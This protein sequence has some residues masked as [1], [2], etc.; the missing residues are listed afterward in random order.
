MIRNVDLAA[1]LQDV[2][3]RAD[4]A[5]SSDFSSC[6]PLHALLG[7]ALSVL[8]SILDEDARRLVL[9]S[10]PIS[11]SPMG[12]RVTL[13]A[14]MLSVIKKY[15]PPAGRAIRDQALLVMSGLVAIDRM[16]LCALK[17]AIRW[18]GFSPVSLEFAVAVLDGEIVFPQDEAE[19][20]RNMR[21]SLI[22]L[23]SKPGVYKL[24]RFARRGGLDLDRPV[25]DM[26]YEKMIRAVLLR[27]NHPDWS[28]N[29][30]AKGAGVA[31]TSLYDWA[32]YRAAKKARC[33]RKTISG[34][35][36]MIRKGRLVELE[37]KVEEAE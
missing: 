23:G 20:V 8:F 29:E 9:K 31:R 33:P 7:E 37:H 22:S 35:R 10:A 25:K 28:D 17:T 24:R 4:L 3:D 26:K 30:I 32:L 6:S 5:V 12:A 1:E 16:Y 21:Q 27:L 14:R 11:G 2:L 36:G 19:I 34:K 15:R 18:P 13:C